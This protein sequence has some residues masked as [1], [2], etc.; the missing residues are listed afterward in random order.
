MTE[1]ASSPRNKTTRELHLERTKMWDASMENHAR[2]V[3][4]DTGM[5]AREFTEERRCPACAGENRTVLFQKSGGTYVVCGNCRMIYLNPAFKDE[6]L[7]EYYRGNHQLQ[8]EIVASDSEFYSGLYRKGLSLI[9]RRFP[10]PGRIL[11]VGC[12][13]GSFLDI[14]KINGWKCHGLELNAKEAEVARSKGH[15]IQE[16]LIGV[17]KFDS[18]FSAVALWDVFEHIKNGKD[19]L[20]S[21]RRILI[22]D[23]VVF[24][25]CPSRDA[26]AARILQSACNMFDGLEHVNLYGFESLCRICEA[27]G[28]E[29][30][31][32]QTVISEIG[33]INNFLEYE[34]P[35]L[36]PSENKESIMNLISDDAIHQ[37]KLGYKFQACLRVR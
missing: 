6:Y 29:L 36:G 23:G 17:A 26:L 3:D 31:D 34:N 5:F 20:I 13:T 14:A 32:Y 4:P 16:T 21:A 18:R 15:G 7:E 1:K 25:Q 35:Y 27:T 33:V 30:L 2:Y 8:G 9:S 12:S 28:F 22:E 24:L 19:F 10:E 11:D 37:S